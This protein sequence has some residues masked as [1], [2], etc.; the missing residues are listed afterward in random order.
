MSHW[1][2]MGVVGGNNLGRT[3]MQCPPGPSLQQNRL[4]TS[5][6]N[7]AAAAAVAA[8]IKPDQL[9]PHNRYVVLSNTKCFMVLLS[10]FYNGLIFLKEMELGEKMARMK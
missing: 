3:G 10:V 6:L 1:K 2:D 9:W 7:S 5:G 4:N 8:G